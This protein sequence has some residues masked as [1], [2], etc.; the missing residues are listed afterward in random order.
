MS[1]YHTLHCEK[2]KR[3]HGKPTNQ[4]NSI[5]DKQTEKNCSIMML[6]NEI[7]FIVNIDISKNCKYDRV[8]ASPHLETT[9]FNRELVEDVVSL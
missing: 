9:P 3:L 6:I 1:Q 5:T 8:I 2:P 4:Q 7:P